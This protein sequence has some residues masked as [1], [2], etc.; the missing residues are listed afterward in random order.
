ME[1]PGKGTA[2]TTVGD[3]VRETA[4]DRETVALLVGLLEGTLTTDAAAMRF[5]ALEAKLDGATASLRAELDGVVARLDASAVWD[6][7]GIAAADFGDDRRRVDRRLVRIPRSVY[8]A[9]SQRPV[10]TQSEMRAAVCTGNARGAPCA[11]I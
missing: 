7:R 4:K 1:E 2:A 6:W 10:H 11:G 9:V 3:L 8:T 5:T